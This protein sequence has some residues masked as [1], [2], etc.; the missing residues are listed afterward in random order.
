M[1]NPKIRVAITH[2]DTNGIGYEIILK[3]IADPQLLDICTPI[4]YGSSK[5]LAY[6]RKAIDMPGFQ[7]NTI[8]RAD[9]AV[10][11]L[12]NLVDV[13]GK[14]ELPIDLGRP[15]RQAGAAA[16]AALEA[17]VADLK[18]GLVDVLVT[19]PINKENIQSD[20]FHF[21][22]HTDYLEAATAAEHQ[23]ALMIM[24]HDRLRVALATIHI[25][26]A[27]VHEVLSTELIINRLTGFDASLRRD[28]GIERP[29]IAVLGLNPHA[30]EGGLLG[31]EE[32]SVILPALQHAGD[33][34][35]LLCFGPYPADGFFGSRMWEHFD[36]V[37][38]MY[39]DQGLI[40]FKTLAMERGVNFTAGLPIVRTSPD[41]GTGYDIA[42]QNLA[43]EQSL[44]EAIYLAI[45]VLRNRERF[46]Q[47]YAD[48][49]PRLYRDRG[50][51]N[52]KLD[53]TQD[54]LGDDL[55]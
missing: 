49:L 25:P 19:A 36:G 40:P 29:R 27:A 43:N 24:A 50:H 42:G 13:I 12:P 3:T 21:T 10:E 1:P 2:G 11:T 14:Q 51:D 15:S 39:H 55:N 48:P 32:Q 54:P 47:A 26:L 53:L 37:L 28:F 31:H 30:G 33:K 41:H 20:Q 6:H 17:A 7:I 44:R 23:Q 9:Q 18:A 22:G 4:I 45:D 46:D 52:E 5:A 8:A 16:F 34:M 35:G 38:A